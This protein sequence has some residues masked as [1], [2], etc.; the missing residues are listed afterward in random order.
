MTLSNGYPTTTVIGLEV[1]VQLKTET[2]LFCG[3]STTFG[4]APNTQ[5]CPVCL[6]L[7]GAL[8]VMNDAAI[9][10]SIRAGLAIDCS[11]PPMTKWDRKQYFYPDLPKGYQISQFDLPICADG[12]LEIPDPAN[13]EKTRHIGIIRAHLEEDAGKSMHDEAAGRGDTRIDL[14]RCGTPLLEIVSQ[15]DLRSSAEAKAYLQELK[16]RMTHLGI[17]DCE[18]QEGSLRVDANVN[19]HIEVDG[20]K[21][22]T[23]IVEVK[24]MNSFRAVERAIEHEVDRQ[25]DL[26]EDTGKT[27]EDETKT[28][29]GWDDG[30]GKTFLQREKE[31][32][33]D[34]RYFPD[35]DL[36]PIR[37]PADR[38]EA[39][40]ASLGELPAALRVRLENQYG[41]K[42]Y[43]ADVIVNQGPALIAY[44]ETAGTKSGDGKRTSSWIQQDVMRTIKDREIDIDQFPVSADELGELLRRVSKGEID[45]TRA[46]DV[47]AHMIEHQVTVEA[48]ITALGIESVDDNELESL[49]KELLDA[50]PQVV[51]DFKGGKQQAVGSLIGQAKKRN[52]NANPQ[53]VRETLIKLLQA[54]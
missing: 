30:A 10:L 39:A 46:R 8:P 5:V 37:L 25:Y 14:N 15:P 23:P 49:C 33:A 19:L 13:P 53:V 27:I 18:M 22:A 9:E 36:L 1:H 32:S 51:E 35:P 29:R 16:L 4:A 43:D 7:P 38:I 48:A 31:E 40:R 20:K 52:P 45:N 41:I 17:S 26:W 2:K 3:C 11:I 42:P 54:M 44:F 24:N 6:G 28:T 12:F 50:N 34:Y 47:F 21:I